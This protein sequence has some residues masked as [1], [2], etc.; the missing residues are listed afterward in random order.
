MTNKLSDKSY[1][2]KIYKNP[3]L[4]DDNKPDSW[5]KRTLHY[6]LRGILKERWD[7]SY[8]DWFV[9]DVLFPT[10][11]SDGLNGK[12]LE[13]G[14]APGHHVVRFAKMFG[15]EPFG[16]EYAEDGVIVNKETFVKNE[17][18]PNNV[19]HADFFSDDITD[20]YQS[21][22]DVVMSRGFIEHFDDPKS[23]ITRHV[24]L[25]KPG[26]RIIVS[27]P[28]IKGLNYIAFHFLNKHVID[29]HNLNIMSLVAFKKI[30]DDIGLECQF[31]DY[32]GTF[33]TGLYSSDGS[34]FSNFVKRL[35][36]RI[37]II[38]NIVL[39]T[40]AGR[41]GLDCRWWSPYLFF[42]GKKL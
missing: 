38:L 32:C 16:I 28:N 19:I 42:I 7:R 18:D 8:S 17:F 12:I 14:S 11:L 30:F 15:M 4:L 33:E 6:I 34:S 5:P 23:V 36:W 40:I 20:K 13:I 9:W 3:T 10:Y 37:Q 1:W 21:Y 25:L 27:I 41:R 35:L 2:N 29:I 39:F 24:N 31:C 22:F 26:G